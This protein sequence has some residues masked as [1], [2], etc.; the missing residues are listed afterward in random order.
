[1]QSKSSPGWPIRAAVGVLVVFGL[2]ACGGSGVVTA[3]GDQAP[4]VNQAGA[5]DADAEGGEA[6]KGGKHPRVAQPWVPEEHLDDIIGAASVLDEEASKRWPTEFAGLWIDRRTIVISFTEGAE[7]KVAELREAIQQP[8]T[9]VA[10][11]GQHPLDELRAHQ[12]KMITDREH[13]S[14]GDH[15]ADMPAAIVETKGNYDLGIDIKTSVVTVNVERLS[16]ELEAAFGEYYGADVIR[17]E[18]G[19]IVPAG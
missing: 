14:E 11:N 9:I 12:Q 15:P 10:V 8:H 2:T 6:K 18:E 13:L 19:M 17:V 16:P 1:M 3:D 4:L 5:T 7:E